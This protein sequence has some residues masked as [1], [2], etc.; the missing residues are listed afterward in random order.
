MVRS[1]LLLCLLHQGRGRS[2]ESGALLMIDFQEVFVT[3]WA[4]TV[5]GVIRIVAI[6]K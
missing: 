4:S 6:L 1:S 3:R 2:T 5:F